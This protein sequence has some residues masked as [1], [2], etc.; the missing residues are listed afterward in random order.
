M[1]QKPLF[2]GCQTESEALTPAR[3]AR[4]L[5]MGLELEELSSGTTEKERKVKEEAETLE[6]VAQC[7]TMTI[8]VTE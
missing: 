1:S 7:L 8:L 2:S 6:I 3:V 5:S 4:C